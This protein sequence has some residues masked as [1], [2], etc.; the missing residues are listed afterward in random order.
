MLKIINI[1]DNKCTVLDEYDNSM[2]VCNFDFIAKLSELVTIV[3][4]LRQ[5][6]GEYKGVEAFNILK[7][8]PDGTDFTLIDN[9]SVLC[10][11]IL[12]SHK[13]LSVHGLKEVV[14]VQI[15]NKLKL[16]SLDYFEI[17]GIVIQI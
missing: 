13:G 9:T 7:S 16:Y 6:S 10:K 14:T 4:E 12:Y 15:D 2:E 8:L 1:K 11:K 17:C 5:I 3:K